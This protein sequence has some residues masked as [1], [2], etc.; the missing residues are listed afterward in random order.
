MNRL[1]ALRLQILVA[2][3]LR[4]QRI[5]AGVCLQVASVSEPLG[6]L[7]ALGAL[8]ALGGAR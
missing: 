5:V 3:A 1:A 6:D 7:G 2:W 8:G 4:K